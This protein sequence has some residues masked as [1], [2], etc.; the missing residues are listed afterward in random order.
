[1]TLTPSQ[2][3]HLDQQGFLLIEDVLS[4]DRL[5]AVQEAFYRVEAETQDEWRDQIE[6]PPAFRPYGT[7]PN[8]HVVEPIVDRDDVFLE[9][10]EH[11]AIVP[12]LESFVGPDVMMIDNAFHSKPCRTP[13]HTKWHRDAPDGYHD[14]DGWS[15]EDAVWWQE[16]GAID[17]P[18]LKVKV[19]YFVDDVR[20]ETGPFSVLPGS[21]KDPGVE[22]PEVDRLEDLE[23]HVKLTGKA[24]S[25]LI[26]NGHILHTATDNT[27][28]RARK[29]LLYNFVHF[30]MKQ[31]DICVPKG[32]FRN[33]VAERSPI[34][35]QLMGL[36]RMTRN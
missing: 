11:R 6:N 25:A 10:L 7:G 31:Y 36:E 3:R 32:G 17:K 30:G 22:R 34:C 2:C 20:E 12:I 29:M 9:L 26:W 18:Y 28:S 1:M 5:S 13:A 14:A 23:G 35:R 8:A 16:N 15:D 21:H 24:G 27:D 33:R 19:F 4:G